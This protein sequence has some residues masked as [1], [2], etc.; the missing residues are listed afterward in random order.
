MIASLT[1]FIMHFKKKHPYKNAVAADYN[2]AMLLM[3]AIFLGASI[4]LVLHDILPEFY[5]ELVLL[6]LIALCTVKSV[7]QGLQIWK[8]E[9]VEREE[10]KQSLLKKEEL[11][12]SN[13]DSVNSKNG[14]NK[15]D[16]SDDRSLLLD[17]CAETSDFPLFMPDKINTAESPVME[18]V[19]SHV[20]RNQELIEK[21]QRGERTHCQIG[22]LL[23]IWVILVAQILTSLFKNSEWFHQKRFSLNWWLLYIGYIIVCMIG[24]VYCYF[25][26]H[27]ETALKKKI[28]FPHSKGE[29]HF[30]ASKIIKTYI[31]SVFAGGIAAMIGVGGGIL[32][33]PLLLMLGYHPFVAGSTSMLIIMYASFSNTISFYFSGDLKIGFALWLSLWTCIGV[34]LGLTITTRIVAKTGRQSIL[35]F[36]L[37]G[38]M[39]AVI[40]FSITFMIIGD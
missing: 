25:Q 17:G 37:G 19:S 35:I 10:R 34:V 18:D 3:P 36:I 38:I 28:N 39:T 32:Y 26:L 4:G 24:V 12:R 1:R 14:I 27:R 15:T 40:I 2:A 5:Q 8:K 7:S 29:V 22:K 20:I 21:L 11:Q 16:V 23:P 31:L 9:T 6:A 33:V 30:T 13:V